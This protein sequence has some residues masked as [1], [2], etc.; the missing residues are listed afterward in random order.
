MTRNERK[1]AYLQ[2]LDLMEKDMPFNEALPNCVSLNY[3]DDIEIQDIIAS[4]KYKERYTF[5]TTTHEDD[6]NFIA[7]CIA[8]CDEPL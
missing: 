2:V 8:L 1:K 4:I 6:K 3:F 5:F 7:L